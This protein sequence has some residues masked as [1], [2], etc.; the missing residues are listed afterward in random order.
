MAIATVKV[1]VAHFKAITLQAPQLDFWP[2]WWKK[3]KG[4]QISEESQ[5]NIFTLDM[6]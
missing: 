3:S 5:K 6:I 1:G 2:L 4:P